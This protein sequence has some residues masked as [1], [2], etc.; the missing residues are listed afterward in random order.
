MSFLTALALAK[1]GYAV[2]PVGPNKRPWTPHGVHNA[3]SVPSV[4]CQFD[5]K[6]AACG[7][8]T[9]EVS[10]V[11]ILDIDVRPLPRLIAERRNSP[12]H[13]SKADGVNGFETLEA[14]GVEL[15]ETLSAST[16]TSEGRHLWIKHIP[17]SRSKDL[18]AGVEWFSNG[19][20]AVVSPAP[21]RAWLNDLPIADAPEWLSKLV[22]SERG[23]GNGG[24]LPARLLAG[25]AVKASNTSVPKSLYQMILR[26]MPKARGRDQRCAIRILAMLVSKR[27]GRNN[28]LHW[29]SCR[30]CELIAEGVINASGSVALLFEASKLN[31][32][33]AKDGEEVVQATIMSGLGLE[34]WPG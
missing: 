1:R 8:A 34:E 20:L 28:A 15:P 7:V 26:L 23:R 11:D 5:W 25:T 3:S 17:G 16:P 13:S 21:G 32:Y 24:I 22:L 12:T 9:G 4:F 31:G 30:F 29:A 19:K 18:G 6:G 27:S 33:L 14:L 10:G 2:L